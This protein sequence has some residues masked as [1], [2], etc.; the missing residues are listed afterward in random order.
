MGRTID[1]VMEVVELEPA[2]RIVMRSIRSPFPMQVT[3]AFSPRGAETDV[4]IRVEGGAGWVY[5]LA[6]P[7][8]T[9]AVRARLSGDLKRLRRAIEE[10]SA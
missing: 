3:Y 8:M 2:G 1:Y 5:R 10:R 7:L 6:G 9:A 4:S